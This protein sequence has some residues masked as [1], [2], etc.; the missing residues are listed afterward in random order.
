MREEVGL[1]VAVTE[2]ICTVEHAY[3]HFTISLTAFRCALRGP[4]S[5]LTCDRPTKWIRL[6]E[7]GTLPFPAAN[8]KIFARLG[9][10]PG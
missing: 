1:D 8:H 6:D 4:V 10:R 5:A 9:I 2:E 7:L 3:S